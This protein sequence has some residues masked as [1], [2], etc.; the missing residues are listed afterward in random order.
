MHTARACVYVCACSCTRTC[1]LRAA[2]RSLPGSVHVKVLL[3]RLLH[4]PGSGAA[5]Q[6]GGRWDR[7]GDVGGGCPSSIMS[8]SASLPL[9]VR[10]CC[11]PPHT[12]TRTH[13]HTHT[14]THAHTR[15]ASSP[16][17]P[18]CWR[19][20]I[21][22]CSSP[23]EWRRA[24]GPPV[25]VRVRVYACL[26]I[27]VCVYVCSCAAVRCGATVACVA[28]SLACVRRGVHPCS[29][30]PPCGCLPAAAAS[31]STWVWLV[32]PGPTWLTRPLR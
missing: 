23:G 32:P 26:C 31:G 22:C 27:S 14:H 24:S 25:R 4:K 20:C 10:C 16:S 9:C 21:T 11:C 29:L 19:R 2:R 7:A 15:T 3:P 13:T 17:S 8:R 28:T 30:L 6:V 12:H 18:R 5:G 1:R